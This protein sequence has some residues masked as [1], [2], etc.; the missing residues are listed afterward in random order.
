MSFLDK[1]KEKAT[2]I[3][4]QAKEKVD[5]FKDGRKVDDLLADLGR[6][7][8]RQHTDRSEPADHEVL[9]KLVADLKILEAEGA[10]V[11][12]KEAPREETTVAP[13]GDG[14]P[15]PSAPPTATFPNP[16]PPGN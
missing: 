14:S 15:L 11:L 2:Q 13:E 9:E 4:Q 8:Y 12:P 6:I 1:A 3:A 5:D 7:V 16:T 10:E